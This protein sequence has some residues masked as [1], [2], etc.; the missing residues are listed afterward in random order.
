MRERL[1]RMSTPAS[2]RPTCL[3]VNVLWQQREGA[4][5]IVAGLCTEDR[6][7]HVL[8][9]VCMRDEGARA[10]RFSK[11]PKDVRIWLKKE[12]VCVEAIVATR[13]CVLMPRGKVRPQP[14]MHRGPRERILLHAHVT[15]RVED[16]SV[17]GEVPRD[18]F[19]CSAAAI[20]TRL[21]ARPTREVTP[22]FG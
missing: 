9:V 19:E 11:H 17:F 22:R 18:E 15:I 8:I 14:C 12:Q 10:R 16:S 7:Q 2:L 20:H 13:G 21:H 4:S 1:D 5:T 6:L 3:S